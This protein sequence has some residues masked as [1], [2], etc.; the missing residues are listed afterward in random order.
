LVDVLYNSPDIGVVG[1]T[2]LLYGTN[3]VIDDAGMKIHFFGHMSNIGRWREYRHYPKRTR[4]V[5]CVNCLAT[6]REL[7]DKVGPL[8]EAYG[9][10]G[11]DADYCLRAKRFGYRIVQVPDAITY[12]KVSASVGEDT[13]RQVYFNRRAEIRVAL[14][15]YPL[16]QMLLALFWIGFRTAVDAALLFPPFAK[17]VSTT[18]YPYLAKRRTLKHFKA[19]LKAIEWNFTRLRLTIADRSTYQSLKISTRATVP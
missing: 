12:H 9:L 8:D 5:G 15:L 10:Y 19:S 3:G 11:E 17:L 13:P 16:P 18:P 1:G 14:K 2:R 6:R 7:I 4:E